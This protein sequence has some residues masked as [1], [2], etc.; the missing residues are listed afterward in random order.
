[1]PLSPQY[2]QDPKVRI[3]CVSVLTLDC[4]II[5]YIGLFLHNGHLI[6][7]RRKENPI[8]PRMMIVLL[9]SFPAIAKICRIN[10]TNAIIIKAAN[11]QN[12]H[13]CFVRLSH[14]SSGML[15]NILKIL[16]I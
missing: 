6:E 3:V 1:M 11:I 4:L 7:N 12:F 10:N 16:S 9:D 8:I 2:G 13:N 15:M 14:A 5:L